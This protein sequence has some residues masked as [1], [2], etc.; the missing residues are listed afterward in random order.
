MYGYYSIRVFPFGYLRVSACLQLV[1][2]FRSLP[3]PSSA[4]S[5][6]ASTV[7]PYSLDLLSPSYLYEV[8]LFSLYNTANVL[9]SLSCFF[10]STLASKLSFAIC[11]VGNCFYLL[12]KNFSIIH[13][14]VFKEPFCLP[15]RAGGDK[16]N[17]TADPLL[18]RQVLSQLSY[19]PIC[20]IGLN[21]LEPSTSRLSG[22]RSNQLSYRPMLIKFTFLPESS[23]K[24]KQLNNL[25][26]PRRRFALL[27]AAP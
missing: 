9:Y 17:R 19:T 26:F 5:A 13:C 6:K 20:L 2:A 25:T 18:A 24:I 4:L 22:V 16:Q 15:I 10:V 11:S 27:F 21:G 14:V 3:R 8:D 1:V 12:Q 23:L 7:C